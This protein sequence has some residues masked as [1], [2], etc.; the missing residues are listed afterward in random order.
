MDTLKEIKIQTPAC[1][2]QQNTRSKQ[3]LIKPKNEFQQNQGKSEPRET[4]ENEKKTSKQN[5]EGDQGSPREKKN[6]KC[7]DKEHE[8][9]FKNNLTEPNE[10][11][12]G[13][14]TYRKIHIPDLLPF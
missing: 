6:I 2:I 4:K 10:Y 14:Q 3:K 7:K 1:K 13:Y 11:S 8:S 12:K 5:K 9:V